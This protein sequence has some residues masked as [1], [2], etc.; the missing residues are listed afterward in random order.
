MIRIIDA[1]A[2]MAQRWALDTPRG[3][4]I[5]IY[6]NLKFPLR[7]AYL[8]GAAEEDICESPCCAGGRLRGPGS[9]LLAA[10]QQQAPQ[11]QHDSIGSQH[12]ACILPLARKIACA[13]QTVRQDTFRIN[14]QTVLS[15]G[16]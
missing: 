2:C 1:P 4:E 14:F 5:R 3:C 8:R 12:L 9:M 13:E 10:A 16:V 11:G 7:A 15:K 6:M